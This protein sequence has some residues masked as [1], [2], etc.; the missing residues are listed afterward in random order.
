[1]SCS[2]RGSTERSTKSELYTLFYDIA[3]AYDSVQRDVLVRAMRR[4]RMPDSFV[5]LVADSL[6]GLSSCVRT[7]YGVSRR[8]DV[9]RSLRQGCPLAPLLFVV[10]MD[11]LHDGLEVN[12][13]SGARAG[14]VL[15]LRPTVELQISSL[16]YADDTN[17]LANNLPNLSVLNDWMH[18][19]L[20][21]NSLRLN[22][23]KCELVGTDATARQSQ[24]QPLQQLASP[25]R[26]MP[27]S[28]WRTTLPSATS[29]CTVASMESGMHSIAS[30]LQ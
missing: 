25:S 20:R 29:A 17:I 10:L 23:G 22:H 19:F 9:Q 28:Q 12:P 5:E 18:Y 21:F 26:V 13:F 4:L 3:Q 30:R 16:G 7:A 1:M 2:T 27:L 6:T 14:L 24:L 8:F 11:A 15:P